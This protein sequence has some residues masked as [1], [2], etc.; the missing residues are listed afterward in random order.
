ML[1][2]EGVFY[3]FYGQESRSRSAFGI[4][5]KLTDGW[6]R[7]SVSDTQR[8]SDMQLFCDVFS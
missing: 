1:W 7:N 8:V 2:S 6:S 4:K 3:D 5:L